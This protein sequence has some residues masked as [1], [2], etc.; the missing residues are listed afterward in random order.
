MS[1]SATRWVRHLE[2]YTCSV[3]AVLSVVVAVL[4]F[5]GILHAESWKWLEERVPIITLLV[6]GMSLGLITSLIVHHMEELE[7]RLHTMQ[8]SVESTVPEKLAGI[9][10][11]VDPNL[12]RVIGSHVADLLEQLNR[13]IRNRTYEL[14]DVELFRAFYKGALEAY[15]GSHFVATSVPSEKFFWR[16]QSTER[17]IAQFIH[18][19]GKMTRIFFISSLDEL[20]NEETRR[21]LI[22][23][24]DMGVEVYTAT[25]GGVPA[26][27]RR[28]FM[29]EKEGRIAWEP[30]RAPDNSITGIN[31]TSDPDQT[32]AFL[33]SFC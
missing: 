8:R 5:S 22:T 4:D 26:P 19:G 24:M 29:V 31:L 20:N 25:T 2:I 13:L 17:A 18:D 10:N 1:G 23:Q 32:A 12:D 16:N 9:R 33:R 28:F 15:K 11:L 6:A 21:I 14:G 3:A 7:R 30:F 27:L